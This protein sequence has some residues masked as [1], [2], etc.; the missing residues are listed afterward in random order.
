MKNFKFKEWEITFLTPCNGWTNI[1]AIRDVD[2]ETRPTRMRNGEW[3]NISVT[4]TRYHLAW[5]GF[6]FAESIELKTIRKKHSA[7]LEAIWQ[8]ARGSE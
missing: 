6:R 4:R 8:V 3:R 7:L 5:N 1:K 2:T